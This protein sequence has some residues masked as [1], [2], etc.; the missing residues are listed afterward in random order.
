MASQDP[1]RHLLESES[2]AVSAVPTVHTARLET[3]AHEDIVFDFDGRHIADIRGLA[4]ILTA[5]QLAGK[6]STV[7][8]LKDVPTRT[9]ALLRALGVDDLFASF[10]EPT[11]PLS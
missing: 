2:A 11:S 1:N 5:Q 6:R 7:V 10:P 3:P 4:M 8:W 9:W